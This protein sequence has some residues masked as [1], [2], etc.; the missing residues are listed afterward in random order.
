RGHVQRVHRR[1]VQTQGADAVRDFEMYGHASRLTGTNGDW[2]GCGRS[3][4]AGGPG[5][6]PRDSTARGLTA[7]G[8][9]AIGQTWPVPC[10]ARHGAAPVPWLAPGPRG[11]GEATPSTS[12]RTCSSR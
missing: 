3:H 5:V 2:G 10:P 11:T 8:V 4:R 1:A 9:G 6:G 7:T 12:P